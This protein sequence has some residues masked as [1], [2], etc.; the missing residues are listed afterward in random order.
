[1]K[2]KLS[3]AELRRLVLLLTQSVERG[4]PEDIPLRDRAVA[5]LREFTGRREAQRAR[6]LATKAKAGVM[7]RATYPNSFRPG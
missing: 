5:L 3:L 2:W 6:R 4:A 1:M 7:A